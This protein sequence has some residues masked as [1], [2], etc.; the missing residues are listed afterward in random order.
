MATPVVT[1][2]AFRFYSDDNSDPDAMTALDTQGTNINRQTGTGNRFIVRVQLQNDNTANFNEACQW[3]YRKNGGTWTTLD[4]SS[5][6]ARTTGGTPAADASCATSILT[7]GTGTYS[8]GYYNE[9][10]G[11]TPSTVINK[12]NHGEMAICVYLVDADVT[13][14]DTVEFRVTATGISSWT[15]IPLVTVQASTPAL[16]PRLPIMPRGGAIQ[17]AS[18]Y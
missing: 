1:Q 12:N 10:D 16:R 2:Q 9:D 15:A 17:R 18:S 4:A 5:S 8:A 14:S 7:G 11:L 13:A 6:N 3:Q